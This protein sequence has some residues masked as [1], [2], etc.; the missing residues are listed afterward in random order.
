MDGWMD[1]WMD[2]A[3]LLYQDGTDEALLLLSMLRSARQ[4]DIQG[5]C[6]S[7][8]VCNAALYRGV[9]HQARFLKFDVHSKLIPFPIDYQ[10]IC[11][12][13]VVR[14]CCMMREPT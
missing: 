8:G 10:G 7:V 13:S 5:V 3:A 1:G 4:K 6:R 2:G 12:T 14:H 11:D 9:F